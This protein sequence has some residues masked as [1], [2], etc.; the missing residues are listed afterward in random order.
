VSSGEVRGDVTPDTA[1]ARVEAR[2]TSSLIAR[3][4]PRRTRRQDIVRPVP[5]DRSMSDALTKIA[6]ASADRELLDEERAPD[7][8][9]APNRSN[10]SGGASGGNSGDNGGDG[11][12]RG[13]GHGN[14]IGRGVGSGLGDRAAAGE[15]L[16]TPPAAPKV[17]KARPAKLIYPS[18]DR[19]VDDVAELFIARVTV[20][21]D[22]YVVGARLTQGQGGPKRD[23]AAGLIF[24]FRYAP[25]LD[26]DGRPIKSQLDQQ[27]LVG[28]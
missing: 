14:G 20:D 8:F 17:S 2:A 11:G 26:D 25:A 13:G 18:R 9:D 7:S 27:F 12:G 10:V 22:G 5:T 6:T 4:D 19:P 24:R 1:V 23:E 28:P 21:R 3:V 15:Q 16:P